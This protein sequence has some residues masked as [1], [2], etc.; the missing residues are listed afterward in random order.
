MIED[1]KRACNDISWKSEINDI[2]YWGECDTAAIVI[3]IGYASYEKQVRIQIV[4]EDLGDNRSG[5]WVDSTECYKLE[6]NDKVRVT[7]D[8]IDASHDEIRVRE[9]T[10]CRFRGFDSDGDIKLSMM[11]ASKCARILTVFYEELRWL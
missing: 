1:I 8:I 7:K 9:G 4:S 2:V 10:I 6:L 3:K 5:C 11:D